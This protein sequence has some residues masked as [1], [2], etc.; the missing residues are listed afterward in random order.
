M[1]TEDLKQ[2]RLERMAFDL[3]N[4]MVQ[5]NKDISK[6][7]SKRT[8]SGRAI[9]YLRDSGLIDDNYMIT[10]KGTNELFDKYADW[11][12]RVTKFQKSFNGNISL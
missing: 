8:N 6:F 5:D 1:E 12:F 10:E 3:L 7:E 9:Q 11:N 4:Q 2:K